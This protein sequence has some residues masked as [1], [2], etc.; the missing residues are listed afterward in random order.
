[1]L[2][3]Y[4]NVESLALILSNHTIRFTALNKMD[5]L[6]EQET[7]DI[8][9]L[10]QFVFVSCWTDDS[11]EQIPMWK[12]YTE[13]ESG[14]RISLPK[15]PF[16]ESENKPEDLSRVTGRPVADKTNG[17]YFKTL[18][19][20]WKMI[21]GHFSLAGPNQ[22]KDI[23][24]KVEYTTDKDKLYPRVYIRNETRQELILSLLG[25][26][27]NTGWSFQ[28]E[29]RYI[30]SFSPIEIDYNDPISSTSKAFQTFEDMVSGIAS[31]P[32]SHYDLPISNEAF[33]QME[34]MLSPK[35][36]AGNRLIV[37]DLV[38]KYNPGATIIESIFKDTIA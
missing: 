12:M 10:G 11:T 8:K 28:K 26:N 30:L 22:Q 33:S 13:M 19:P 25:K 7:A 6:Q 5:D 24:Y 32:F 20:I 15:Y 31:L 3:H 1:M 9:N 17:V 4:T 35:I 34:I 29:W 14:V 38:K 21:E 37:E 23:L 18:I 2:Y 16:Q 27:K 36:S